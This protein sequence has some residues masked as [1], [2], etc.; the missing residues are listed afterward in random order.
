MVHMYKGILLS[1]KKGM[2][3]GHLQRYGWTQSLSYR[4]KKVRKR[5]TNIVCEHIYVESRKVAQMNLFPG[6]EQ[7]HRDWACGREAGGEGETSWESSIGMYIL[8]C[9]KQKASGKLP[10][11][12]G[13]SAQGSV[14]THRGKMG[15]AG[16]RFKREQKFK[17][18]RKKKIS[19]SGGLLLVQRNTMGL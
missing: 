2:K 5:K 13:S 4:V 10:N 9:V 8:L 18:I 15:W 12:T 11:G 7:R 1:H 14:M 3:L 6:R 17:K 16:E 19:F